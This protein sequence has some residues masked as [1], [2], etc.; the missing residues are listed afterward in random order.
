MAEP[1]QDVKEGMEQLEKNMTLRY[2]LSTLLAIGNFLNGTNAKGFELSYLEKVPEVKDT[3]HKQS[4]LHHA[5]SIVVDNYPQSTDLYSEIGAITR[6]AKVDFDQLQENLTMMERRWKA[7]WD[8]LKVMAKH[9][10]KP[11]LKQKMSDFLKDCAERIII[12]KIVHRRINNR[13]RA[14]LLYLGHPAYGVREI[15]VQR[16]SKILSEFALEYRTS[17]DRVLQQKQKRADHRERNKTRGKM[18]MD[19]NAPSAG[20]YV[21]S[22]SAPG[23]VVESLQPQ[24]LGHAEDAAEHEFMK[25]VLKTSLQGGDRETSGVPR[26][27]TRTRSR[28]GRGG[29]V[30]HVRTPP[31]AVGVESQRSDDDEADDITDRIVRSATQG[32]S[33]RAVPRERRRSRFNR[34]SLRRTLKSGLTPDEALLLGF[35]DASGMPM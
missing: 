14:F 29:R 6:S 30:Q 35:A 4:L 21:S 17:R 28:P 25:A 18:I 16:F 11:T 20:Q 27:R 10:M 22:S 23:G 12:L 5:C 2:I 32:T 3:V 1:L 19:V 7:S 15:G 9:E 33:Q 31:A 13:F 34:K 8:H 26:L 24:G